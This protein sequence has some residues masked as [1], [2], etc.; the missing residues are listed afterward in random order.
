MKPPFRLD[1]LRV[2]SFALP[3]L[4]CSLCD[5]ISIGETGASPGDTTADRDWGSRL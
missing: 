2:V 5:S 3:V 1:G 4:G